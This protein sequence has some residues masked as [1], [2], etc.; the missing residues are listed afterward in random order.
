MW[1]KVSGQLPRPLV[2]TEGRSMCTRN[3]GEMITDDVD[4]MTKQVEA[5]VTV[6]KMLS[7]IVSITNLI[8]RLAKTS[9]ELY[10]IHQYS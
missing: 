1:S 8:R 5:A 10:Y 9:V 2:T 3:I 6:Q 7:F 4:V